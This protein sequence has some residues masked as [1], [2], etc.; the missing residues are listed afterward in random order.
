MRCREFAATLLRVLKKVERIEYI[1][2]RWIFLIRLA[3]VTS[4]FGSYEP[5]SLKRSGRVYS[6]PGMHLQYEEMDTKA[7]IRGIFSHHAWKGGKHAPLTVAQ[8]SVI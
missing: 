1:R 3:P 5:A 4:H 2:F 7:K 8:T 6:R